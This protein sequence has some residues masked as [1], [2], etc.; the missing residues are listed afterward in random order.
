MMN[1]QIFDQLLT[2]CGGEIPAI[3][4]IPGRTHDV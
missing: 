3:E 1:Y 2:N 4:Q